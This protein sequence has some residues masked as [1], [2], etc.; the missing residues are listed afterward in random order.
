M[1]TMW[2]YGTVV[3]AVVVLGLGL[4]LRYTV[5]ADRFKPQGY[6][7][8]AVASPEASPTAAPMVSESTPVPTSTPVVATAPAP[9]K[10]PA[11]VAPPMEK[12]SDGEPIAPSLSETGG[13]PVTPH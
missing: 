3:I 6:T 8:P 5:F 11:V 1:Q 9:A 2:M 7:P 12:T 4:L 10:A 13:R